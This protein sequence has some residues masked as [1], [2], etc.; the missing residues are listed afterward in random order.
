[1]ACEKVASDLGLGGSFY[2]VLQFAPPFTSSYSL[3][4][5]Y[6]R[7]F[8]NCSFWIYTIKILAKGLIFAI[9]NGTARTMLG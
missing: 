7:E 1:M 6:N 2:R 8:N 9:I 4:H 5:K 3:L